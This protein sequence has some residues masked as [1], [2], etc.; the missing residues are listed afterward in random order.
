MFFRKRSIASAEDITCVFP[1]EPCC[2]CAR[3]DGLRLIAQDTRLTRYGLILRTESTF[4]LP[5]PFC[6][7]CEASSRRRAP[8][9]F[10]IFLLMTLVSLAALAV[11]MAIGM[12]FDSLPILDNAGMVSVP[13]GIVVVGVWY[14]TRRKAPGQ[15]S[16]YQPVRITRL[17]RELLSDQ[18]RGVRFLMTN[19]LYAERFKALNHEAIAR[20]QVEVT[21]G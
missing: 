11:A 16:F 1:T 13:V 6:E 20:G 10:K 3:V 15:S 12:A 4:H 17:R 9:L 19:S 14:S 5:L 2:N 8:S 21:S 7:L 18:V